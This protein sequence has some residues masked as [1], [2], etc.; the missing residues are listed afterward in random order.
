MD[1]YLAEK[2][3]RKVQHELGAREKDDRFSPEVE[4]PR[5]KKERILSKEESH[6]TKK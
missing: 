5:P 2:A 6:P 4:G 3:C 1:D